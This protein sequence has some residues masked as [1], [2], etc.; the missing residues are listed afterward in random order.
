LVVVGGGPAGAAAAA[1]LARESRGPLLIERTSA[2]QH[3]VCGEFLSWEAQAYLDELGLD[4]LALGAAPIGAVRIAEGA[5]LVEAALPF[6]GLGL[7][8]R[9][10]DEALLARAEALGAE[11]RRGPVVRE[12]APGNGWLAVRLRGGEE[13]AAD[14][15]FLATGKHDLRA[16]RRPASDNRLIGF[17]TYFALAPNQAAE[18]RGAVEVVLFDGGYAGLQM[19][20]GGMTNLCLLARTDLFERAGKSWGRLLG[21]LRERC[22]HLGARLDGAAELLDKPLTVSQVP[23]GFI[24]RPAAD[25]PSG[26]YRLGDQMGVIPSFCGDGMAIALH[27]AKLAARS[28]L[29]HEGAA[30]YHRRIAADVGGPIRL[31]Q[32]VYGLSQAAP[33]RRGLMAGFRLFPGLVG[34]LA[35]WTRIPAPLIR[36]G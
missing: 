16:P 21:L 33:A 1:Y 5:E 7:S 32:R 28:H 17:K 19:V 26:L 34:A 35:R 36:T 30:A 13:I 20:E 4:L 27:S 2:P 31:A 12:V 11:I 22:P 10:L 3:K 25:D 6:A 14:A 23:Y 15:V 24:H 9:S 18:L 8:R 29:A